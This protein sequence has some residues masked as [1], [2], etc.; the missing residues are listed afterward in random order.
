[1]KNLN[2]RI[3]S[4]LAMAT[5]SIPAFAAVDVTAVVAEINAAV[6][7]IG[8]VGAAVL[9]VFVTAAVYKWVRKAL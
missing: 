6:A 7:P 8:L 9:V 4:W 3:V 1:M 2:L 5:A